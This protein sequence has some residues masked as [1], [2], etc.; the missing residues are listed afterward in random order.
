MAVKSSEYFTYGSG[1]NQRNSS[2]LGIINVNFSSGMLEEEF[3]PETELYESYVRDR[4]TPFYNRT[5][6]KP[7]NLNLSFACKEEWTDAKIREVAKWLSPDFYEPMTFSDD[8]FSKVYWCKYIGSTS[9]IHN[10]LRQGYIN[11]TMRCDSPYIYSGI[12]ESPVYDLSANPINGTEVTVSNSGDIEIFPTI[13]IEKV[14]AGDI[15]IT[16]NSDG[17]SALEL[18][19][20]LD[21][22]EV[23][24]DCEHEEL[25]SSLGT[26]LYTPHNDVFTRLTVGD[27]YLVVEGNCHI[28]FQ[29]E[30]RYLA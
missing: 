26:D 16:N 24:I 28:K 6:R 20:L 8:E 4:E 15:T 25:T 11:L 2:D 12:Q 21:G 14:G 7:R 18:T 10:G 13:I 17:G 22:E 3:L 9:F 19:G 23:T 1:S 27:N 29:Y 30:F 5:Q